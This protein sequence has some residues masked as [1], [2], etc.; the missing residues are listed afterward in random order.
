MLKTCRTVCYTNA[1]TNVT[2]MTQIQRNKAAAPLCMSPCLIWTCLNSY[3][4]V[5]E[6]LHP[7]HD[8]L[9]GLQGREVDAD[10][11]WH[12]RDEKAA[13]I[14]R[15]IWCSAAS[16][17]SKSGMLG[18]LNSCHSLRGMTST[19][20][21]WVTTRLTLDRVGWAAQRKRAQVS[22]IKGSNEF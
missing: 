14:K 12:N 16:L 3:Q 4:E 1:A 10:L 22:Q 9:H 15:M 6:V 20:T 13:L 18:S 17:T 8:V 21:S 5:G 11:Q 19:G 7:V 2:E